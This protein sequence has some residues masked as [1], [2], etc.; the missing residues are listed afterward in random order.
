MRRWGFG[1]LVLGAAFG[2]GE[3]AESAVCTPAMPAVSP[4]P[5]D[6]AADVPTNARVLFRHE[7]SQ[8]NSSTTRVLVNGSQVAGTFANAGQPELLR[9]A[10]TEFR[11]DDPFPSYASVE[12]VIGSSSGLAFSES[13]IFTVGGAP[14]LTPPTGGPVVSSDSF[15]DAVGED[16]WGYSIEFEPP[17]DGLGPAWIRATVVTL[18][19]AAI[20]TTAVR[21]IAGSTYDIDGGNTSC[22]TYVEEGTKI[23]VTSVAEDLAGN[24]SEPSTYS[25]VVGP[26]SSDAACAVTRVDHTISWLSAIVLV[27]AARSRRSSR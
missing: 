1:L 9:P 14:D 26:E 21:R 8:I 27:L 5:A 16:R 24:T 22:S 2:S 17:S 20:P 19:L 11:P 4:V 18:P 6:G 10:W 13:V 23:T 25:F 15:S 3:I 12:V 7:S